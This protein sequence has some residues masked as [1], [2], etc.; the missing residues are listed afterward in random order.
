MS[1]T[2]RFLVVEVM[3][4]SAKFIQRNYDEN[5]IVPGPSPAAVEMEGASQAVSAL[6]DAVKLDGTARA[7]DAGGQA[8]EWRSY[9]SS[10]LLTAY[11]QAGG[12]D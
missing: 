1:N 5:S 6:L 12:H 8:N 4:S 2:T 10:A 11:N 7:I 3:R 9:V